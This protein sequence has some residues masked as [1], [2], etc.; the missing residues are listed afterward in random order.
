MLEII[1]VSD[2]LNRSLI[3][4]AKKKKIDYWKQNVYISK[5]ENGKFYFLTFCIKDEKKK[6]N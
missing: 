3:N 2:D 4:E 5:Q 1:S 6:N